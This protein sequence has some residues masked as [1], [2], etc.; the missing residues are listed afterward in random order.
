MRQDKKLCRLRFALLMLVC[1]WFGVGSSLHAAPVPAVSWPA[2]LSDFCLEYL[3]GCYVQCFKKNQHLRNE[4]GQPYGPR[5]VSIYCRRICWNSPGRRQ[6]CR[7]NIKQ[8]RAY[9]DEFEKKE[10]ERLKEE[11]VEHKKETQQ[12][13]KRRKVEEQRLQKLQEQRQE[14]EERLQAQRQQLEELKKKLNSQ[15]DAERRAREAAKNKATQEA[16]A[17]RKELERLRQ[18]MA[19]QKKAMELQKTMVEEEKRRLALL[20]KR[21]ETRKRM[22]A[23]RRQEEAK[24][25]A[26]LE[27]LRKERMDQLEALRKQSQE[28]RE[29]IEEMR[30]AAEREKK[31]AEER[32]RLE[33]EKQAALK[34]QKAAKLRALKKAQRALKRKMARLKKRKKRIARLREKARKGQK[35]R[36]EKIKHLAQE[37]KKRRS[38]RKRRVASVDKGIAYFQE[39]RMAEAIAYFE[40]KGDKEKVEQLQE[41]QRAYRRGVGAY[42]RR[43][44]NKGIPALERAFTLDYDLAEGKSNYTRLIRRMLSRMHAVRGMLAM[45]QREYPAAYL[46]FSSARKHDKSNDSATQQLAKLKEIAGDTLKQGLQIKTSNPNAARRLMRQV[47]RMVPRSDALCKKT[48]KLLEEI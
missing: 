19:E 2:G 4:K 20:K 17:Q 43:N 44:A 13:A 32:Q 36:I 35:K 6:I 28:E 18:V 34:E 22:E 11:A 30:K 5:V 7:M 1:T 24:H 40:K 27:R 47:C 9:A 23:E 38:R 14:E 12:E 3:G 37:S 16:D 45:S 41:F 46:Y 26:E 33:A 8:F 31:L 25:A 21:A 42:R 15:Q 29:R 48:R 10:R 39:G